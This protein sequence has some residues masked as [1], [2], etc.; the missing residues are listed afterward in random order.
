[1]KKLKFQTASSTIITDY[2]NYTL[3]KCKVPNMYIVAVGF[4]K[5]V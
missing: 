4:G 5:E 1:M 3:S 2:I